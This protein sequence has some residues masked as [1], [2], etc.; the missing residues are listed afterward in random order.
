VDSSLII[1]FKS[2]NEVWK[3]QLEQRTIQNIK[4]YLNAACPDMNDDHTR[5]MMIQAI[6]SQKYQLS[7]KMMAEGRIPKSDFPEHVGAGRKP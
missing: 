1:K 6:L 7:Q 2:T 3:C 4:D 5:N